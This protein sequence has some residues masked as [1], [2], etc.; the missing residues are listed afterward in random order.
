MSNGMQV[1]F[2]FKDNGVWMFDDERKQLVR[3]PFVCGIPE[4]VDLLVADIEDA[5]GGFALYFSDRRFPGYR[6]KV[7]LVAPEAG[8]NWYKLTVDG[9]EMKGWL[10][11][12]LFKFFETAPATI[13]AKA[14]AIK[15]RG[16]NKP[17]A[18][19][20]RLAGFLHTKM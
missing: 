15:N 2:P 12:A 1:I 6:L 16:R 19:K 13:Y 17:S 10:C 18:R 3:E 5:D 7:D 9:T 8:G 11:P 20:A 14:E 4:M